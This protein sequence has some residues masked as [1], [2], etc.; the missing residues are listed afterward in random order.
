MLQK[1]YQTVKICETAA[2]WICL[3]S[4]KR[5]PQGIAPANNRPVGAGLP[6]PL[7]LNKHRN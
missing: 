2:N 1:L 3:S 6:C 7:S 5:Q 4:D